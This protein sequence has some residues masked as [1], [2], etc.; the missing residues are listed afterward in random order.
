LGLVLVVVGLVLMTIV[1]PGMKRFPADVDTTR[2]YAGT[3]PVLLDRDSLGFLN[4]VP[5]ELIRHFK[6]EQTD[7]DLALVLEEQ[8]MT[9]GDKTVGHLVKRYAI[10]RE[11]MESAPN[12]PAAWQSLDGFAP[13]EGLVMGWPIGTEKKDYVGWSDDYQATVPMKFEGE[14]THERSGL[15]TYLFTSSGDPRPI[16]P[17]YVAALGLPTELTQEQLATLI[18]GLDITPAIAQALPQV[19][20][21]ANWPDPVPLV[22]DYSYNAEYWIEPT[23]GVLIDT[24]K[25]ETRR[26]GFSEELMT[27]LVERLSRLPGFDPAKLSE[28]LPVTVYKLDYTATTQSVQDAKADAEDAK[29]TI[30]LFGT[31]LPLVLIVGGALLA[32]VGLVL[33]LRR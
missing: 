31:T 20:K 2:L 7:G 10:N 22:Y 17:S 28:L 6:T 11:T 1:V 12:P 14:V 15:K 13:R 19:I 9:A 4:D 5:V 27:G 26:A 8:T 32:L 33:A 24:H 16:V 18:Q 3:M 21:L 23:T 25:V 29:Q 30:D